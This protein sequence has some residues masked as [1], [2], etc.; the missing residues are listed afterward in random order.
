MRLPLFF[1]SFAATTAAPCTAPPGIVP[2]VAEALCFKELVPTN[3]SGVSIRQYAGSPNSTFASSG[4]TGAF[5]GGVQGSIA[6]I[7]S[8]FSGNNDEQR[9][10][11]SARTVPFLITPPAQG[12]Y[13][14]ASMEISPTQFPD[15]FLIPRPN[16][17]VTLS[18]VNAQ[19]N[20]LIASFAYNTTGFPY[21]ENIEE[22][23]G[24]IQNST[25]PSGYA[26]NFSHPLSPTWV[27][28]NG[29]A[30]VNYTSE[31]WMAVY[32]L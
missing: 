23:C 25:L 10:I 29:Q 15:N 21:A 30:D 27:F 2:A 26:V 14:G 22:A 19:L 5:P 12:P 18:L 31:C 11:L 17:G 1:A 6:S 8:Y 4:A 20:T 3:P 16:R 9:N 7:I 28:Y 24:V 13:W 32:A